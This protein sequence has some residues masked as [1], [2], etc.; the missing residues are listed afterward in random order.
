[1]SDA[2]SGSLPAAA[3]ATTATT[4]AVD[5]LSDDLS[6]WEF[7]PEAE[8]P[9]PGRAPSLVAFDI[10]EV[11]IDESRVWEVWADILGISRFTMAA[12]LGAAIAQGLDH[13]EAFAHV[14]PN[15]QWED[16]VEEHERRYGGFMPGD[17]YPDV[18]PCLTELRELGVRVALAGNQPSQRSEQLRELR[19]PVDWLMTSAEIGHEKPDQRFFEAVLARMDAGDPGEVL[20]VGDRVDTD[21]I[22]A[23]ALG[24][25]TCWLRRGPWGHLQDLPDDVEADLALEGLGELPLLLAG[26]LD[27]TKE[28]S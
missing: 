10:G 17:V 7:D 24:L 25:R 8:E 3:E 18:V 28:E 14:A 11:I 13:T 5:D 6:A 2:A 22:P 20:Y 21:V 27:E 15:V 12:V 26:W 23:A 19:L 4:D 9:P 1:M 16:F